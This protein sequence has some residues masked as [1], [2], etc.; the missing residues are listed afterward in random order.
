[1]DIKFWN[2]VVAG[3]CT[4]GANGRDPFKIFGVGVHCGGCQAA[5][6]AIACLVVCVNGYSLFPLFPIDSV[7]VTFRG[8]KIHIT[9]LADTDR[10]INIAGS[11]LHPHDKIM[12]KKQF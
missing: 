12:N 8:K 6:E 1:M 2:E 3:P 5:G 7:S 11:P 9:T 10:I 4:S